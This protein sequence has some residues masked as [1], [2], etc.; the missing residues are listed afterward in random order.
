MSTI[1]NDLYSRITIFFMNCHLEDFSFV[2]KLYVYTTCE[3]ASMFVWQFFKISKH[4]VGRIARVSTASIINKLLLCMMYILHSHALMHNVIYQLNHCC[5]NYYQQQYFMTKLKME[6]GKQEREKCV[7]SGGH[8]TI[9][10]PN[11]YIDKLHLFLLQYLIHQCIEMPPTPAAMKAP[12]TTGTQTSFFPITSH[13]LPF[14]SHLTMTTPVQTSTPQA[15]DDC[16]A[17]QPTSAVPWVPGHG[18]GD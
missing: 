13:I 12:V 16:S 11:L 6:I 4:L 18:A 1:T 17:E 14:I 2:I 3:C 9:T 8:K 15:S 10:V 5:E 7:L